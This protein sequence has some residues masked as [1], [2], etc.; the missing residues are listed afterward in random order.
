MNNKRCFAV[1]VLLPKILLIN[2]KKKFEE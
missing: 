2:K 1:I